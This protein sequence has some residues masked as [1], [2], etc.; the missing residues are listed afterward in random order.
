MAHFA[1][2]VVPWA[3]S[4]LTPTLN[5]LAEAGYEIKDITTRTETTGGGCV[6]TKYTHYDIV[7]ALRTAP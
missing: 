2:D 5:R 7:I 1:M 6:P 4:M 3:K